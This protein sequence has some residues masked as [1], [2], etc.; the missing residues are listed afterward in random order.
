MS[1]AAPVIGASLEVTLHHI[2]MHPC[3]GACSLERV[4]PC[5]RCIAV[6][7]SEC[8][9]VVFIVADPDDWCIHA[10]VLYRERCDPRR[11]L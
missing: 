3:E 6:L 4:C 10:E 8:G 5:G 7:C 9:D 11:Q 1:A 2:A